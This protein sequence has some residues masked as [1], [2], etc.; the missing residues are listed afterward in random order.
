MSTWD[1]QTL[2]TARQ[3]FK[4]L[5]PLM[6]LQWRL[7]LGP[8][9]SLWPETFGQYLVITH[10]GRKT[11]LRR[12]TPVNFAEVDEE[13][14]VTAG[15]GR[16]SDWYRN[17]KANP[18]VEIWTPKGWWTARAEEVP[19]SDPRRLTLLRK[20]IRGSGFAG[21]MFG[22]DIQSMDDAELEAVTRDYRLIHLHKLQ[23]CTGPGGPGDLVWVWP[24]LTLFLLRLA[25][26]PRRQ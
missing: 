18:Q 26:R 23:P 5:N 10:T 3:G 11:G 21:R 12:R 2:E 8:W 19:G 17:L 4:Y 6:L 16:V 22:I 15:F 13:I 9:L 25:L 1:P 14:F 24:V 20:V 7:G